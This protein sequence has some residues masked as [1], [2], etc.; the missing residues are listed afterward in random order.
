M[1]NLDVHVLNTHATFSECSLNKSPRSDG[2]QADRTRTLQLSGEAIAIQYKLCFR[3]DYGDK[4][5]QVDLPFDSFRSAPKIG[6]SGLIRAKAAMFY[7]RLCHS[8]GVQLPIPVRRI[9]S[10]SLPGTT[11]ILPQW[12]KQQLANGLEPWVVPSLDYYLVI[13]TP[14]GWKDLSD[15]IREL[16]FPVWLASFHREHLYVKINGNGAEY[17][18]GTIL[19]VPR[20]RSDMVDRPLMLREVCKGLHTQNIRL[21]GWEGT[22]AFTNCWKRSQASIFRNPSFHS[23]FSDFGAEY[24]T[25]EGIGYTIGR[26]LYSLLVQLLI[27]T[28]KDDGWW[29][30]DDISWPMHKAFGECPGRLDDRR[31]TN[32]AWMLYR[33]GR[34]E[35]CEQAVAA[36]RCYVSKII[37]LV[38]G[39]WHFPTG[40]GYLIP[41]YYHETFWAKPHASLNH[42]LNLANFLAHIGLTDAAR[43]LAQEAW[44]VACAIIRG[45]A[46]I[47]ERWIAENGD[48]VY[49]QHY[50]DGLIPGKDYDTLTLED[51]ILS[52]QIFSR[53]VRDSME[54]IECLISVKKK[55]L[56]GLGYTFTDKDLPNAPG[57][58]ELSRYRKTFRYGILEDIYLADR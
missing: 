51:L 30:S 27:E 34:R 13:F 19:L 46:S 3:A 8:D 4:C 36:A 11:W 29:A 55:F 16:V 9:Y 25:L 5:L 17:V 31:S 52:R 2:D 22:W 38:H 37:A 15:G 54:A 53:K 50:P 40:K 35:C 44:R 56:L 28:Q 42:N 26:P 20:T 48:L 39:G 43:D 33:W 45:I 7:S 10:S 41:D 1:L 14:F 57:S 18:E 23:L 47:K 6:Y 21:L 32:A 58:G 49:A 24:E 12:L